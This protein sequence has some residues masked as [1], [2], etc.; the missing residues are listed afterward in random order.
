MIHLSIEPRT[1]PINAC[2][3][4]RLSPRDSSPDLGNWMVRLVKYAN[5]HPD[6]RKTSIKDQKSVHHDGGERDSWGKQ[7]F[8]I[9]LSADSNK[10][11]LICLF[12][13]L[14]NSSS[15]EMS[16]RRKDLIAV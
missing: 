7:H 16:V 11:K 3:S 13:A 1:S 2:P 9:I 5:L 15:C 14:L 10:L 4:N 6:S 8:L 12:V